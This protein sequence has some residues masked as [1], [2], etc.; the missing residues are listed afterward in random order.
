MAVE[1][2]T[3]LGETTVGAILAWGVNSTVASDTEILVSSR[4]IS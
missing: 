2:R 3:L 1:E 4:T